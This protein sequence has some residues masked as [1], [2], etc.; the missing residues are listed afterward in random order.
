[1]ST[2]PVIAIYGPGLLGGSLAL[3]IQERM[4]GSRLHL[5]ARR[6]G[7]EDAIRARGIQAAFFT[8]A[9][10]AAHEASLI[11]LCTPVETMPDLASHIARAN[12][13]EDCLIT[14][15]GSVKG[16]V[17]RALAP[18][19]GRRFVGSHPMAGSEKTG[20]DAARACLFE[21][22]TC[23]V[24]PKPDDDPE[25]VR[26]LNRFW[27]ALGCR[28]LEMSPED[29]DVKV[30]RISHLPH[31]MAAVTTLAAL[32][33]D[34]EAVAC[35]ANGFRDTTRVAGGDP[36][37]WT[38]IALENRPALV[39]RLQEARSTLTELLEI[40]QKPD[41]EEL[42]RFLAEAQTLRRTVPAAVS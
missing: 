34:P 33:Q 18:I 20:V 14:D 38:G 17:A 39:E 40:L 5:W 9:A 3:A 12:L 30:A 35:V 42:R 41:E 28:V 32:R 25:S 23:L 37:L 11:V 29:H 7:A 8:D 10:A 4:P 19:L 1:M 22:A 6:A 27:T 15:V 13:A 21:N 16:S 2:E 26:R 31:M 36:G 24:T